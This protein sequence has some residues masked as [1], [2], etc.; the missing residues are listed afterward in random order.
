MTPLILGGLRKVWNIF[1]EFIA[2]EKDDNDLVN[3][4]F[5]T[6]NKL[7]PDEKAKYAGQPTVPRAELLGSVV[8]AFFYART[9][10][11]S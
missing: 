6:W 11:V 3:E 1:C 4:L 9:I 8:D 2:P 5:D 10:C 7:S